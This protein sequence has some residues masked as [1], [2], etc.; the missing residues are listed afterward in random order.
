MVKVFRGDV[1][2]VVKSVCSVYATVVVLCLWS[3]G[4]IDNSKCMDLRKRYSNYGTG[5]SA[6]MSD[7]ERFL[8]Q[9][10]INKCVKEGKVVGLNDQ[11]PDL[12]SWLYISCE[13]STM[14]S[15]Q[16]GS[17]DIASLFC[18]KMLAAYEV[19]PNI[20]RKEIYDLK[21]LAE[22]VLYIGDD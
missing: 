12:G 15:H 19:Y 20:F 18:R 21:H 8:T 9:E 2:G 14:L 5:L 7:G 1:R 13:N 3:V 4:V 11:C 17:G 16:T 22:E 10:F 6:W